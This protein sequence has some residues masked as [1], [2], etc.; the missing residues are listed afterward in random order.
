M[1]SRTRLYIPTQT[2]ASARSAAHLRHGGGAAPAAG[3]DA[4]AHRRD[5]GPLPVGRPGVPRARL[6]GLQ[7]L[8]APPLRP[9]LPPT[10]RRLP[11]SAAPAWLPPQLGRQLVCHAPRPRFVST[12]TPSPLPQ[13][14]FVDRG[15]G[16][17]WYWEVLDCCHDRV[18]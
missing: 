13:Q 15:C 10:L 18:V 16:C 2:L 9:R 14:A 1:Q 5:P 4:Q 17:G 3:S 6:H 8:A 11:P 12:T 7:A